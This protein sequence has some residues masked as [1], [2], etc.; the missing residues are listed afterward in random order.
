MMHDEHGD[1][2]VEMSV[3]DDVANGTTADKEWHIN[4][5]G[6]IVH[7]AVDEL[8]GGGVATRIA[9]SSN[10]TLLQGDPFF[11]SAAKRSCYSAE[12]T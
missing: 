7:D 5:F 4:L 1:V 11:S 10:G 6:E 2:M 9:V 3:V 8:N 12:K